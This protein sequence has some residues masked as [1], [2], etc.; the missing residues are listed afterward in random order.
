MIVTAGGPDAFLV[1]LEPVTGDVIWTTPG[2]KPA[3]CS[4]ICAEFSGRKQVIGYDEISLGGWD[5]ETGERLWEV[6]P[7]W[8]GDFNVPTPIALGDGTLLVTTENNGTRLFEFDSDGRIIPEP[9]AHNEELA[10]D[11]ST[12]VV[13]GEKVFGVFGEMYCLD[14]SDS[15]STVWMSEDR[16]FRDYASLVASDDRVLVTTTDGE[17]ML[18]DAAADEC[19]LLG[20]QQ[21]FDDGSEVHSHPAL[22]G[23]RLF[24]RSMTTLVCVELP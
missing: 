18:F 22:V 3:Y 2:R 13:V 23:K 7:P 1:A 19:K 16:V 10:P 12:P 9:I 17:I 11:S 8:D 4:F 15:L 6:I 21:L 5:L 14:L 20:R 24:V